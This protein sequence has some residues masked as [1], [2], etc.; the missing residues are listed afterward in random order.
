M[1]LDPQQFDPERGQVM[2]LLGRV[3]HLRQRFPQP[4]TVL[5]V[6]EDRLTPVAPVHHAEIAQG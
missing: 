4:Q 5:A 6:G 1:P 3:T 2:R